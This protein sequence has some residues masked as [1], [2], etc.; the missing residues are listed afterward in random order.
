MFYPYVT[1]SGFS[2]GG[3]ACGAAY[4]TYNTHIIKNPYFHI[5]I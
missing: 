1:G 5:I 3:G 4:T 2:S